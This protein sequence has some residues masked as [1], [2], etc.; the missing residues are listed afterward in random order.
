MPV[1]ITEVLGDKPG[2][3]HQ[4]AGVIQIELGRVRIR[5]EGSVDP[6]NLRIILEHLGR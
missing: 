4:Q 6:E 5:V 1:R 2:A 3:N